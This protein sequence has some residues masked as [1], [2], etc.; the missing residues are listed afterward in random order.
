MYALRYDFIYLDGDH[1]K[2]AVYF[3]SVWSF[4]ICKIDGYILFDDYTWRPET[5]EGIDL[6]LNEFAGSL[7]IIRKD[8]QV[9][10]RKIAN[11]YN[12]LTY[13]YYK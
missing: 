9:L 2:D 8:Y 4:A 5:T 3:D 12:E 11:Q 1:R 7:E 6:F 13:E 10:I